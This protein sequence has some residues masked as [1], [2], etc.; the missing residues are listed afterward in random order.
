MR[1][2]LTLALAFGATTTA[3]SSVASAQHHHHGGGG[4]GHNRGYGNYGGY[5][6]YGRG[7]L[8]Y[9]GFGY[10]SYGFGGLGY[11]TYGYGGL[12]GGYSG[13]SLSTGFGGLNYYRGPV[14]A[15]PFYGAY[16]AYGGWPQAYVTQAP[17]IPPVFAYTAP[18]PANNP[19]L[20]EDAA[21]VAPGFNGA[22]VPGFDGAV[23]PNP[24][25]QL[26]Q[27]L[28]EQLQAEPVNLL[29][30]QPSSAEARL[31]SLRFQA[32]G[33]EWLAKRNWMQAYTHYKQAATTAI[34]LPA[35]R[36]RMAVALC[37]MNNGDLAVR[38][39][40]RAMRTDPLCVQTTD[41]LETIFGESGAIAR[42][43]M[44]LTVADWVR[45]DVR[46]PNRIL[47]MGTMLFLNEDLDQALP[48]LKTASTLL[49]SPEY[50]QGFFTKVEFAPAPDAKA[51]QVIEPGRPQINPPPADSED[52]PAPVAPTVTPSVQ[53]RRAP[54]RTPIGP[55]V[56]GVARGPE[57]VSPPSTTNQG[58]ELVPPTI[59]APQGPAVV[60]FPT[61]PAPQA[62]R[63]TRKIGPLLPDD[64][65]GDEF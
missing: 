8:G 5:R 19:V 1:W 2:F 22:A 35:P 55:K 62:V 16:G 58:P 33:D 14:Y 59:A 9:S 32:Q 3:F 25:A 37:A 34:D 17:V 45:E 50:M 29:N 15:G 48:F 4:F 23:N 57:I 26:E 10:R 61:R 28:R 13:F 49:G 7:G 53:N 42:N 43:G 11:S 63:P 36:L 54:V 27:Q 39:V 41:R 64:R 44:L 21:G 31:K 56:N 46:D 65:F 47:V 24:N 52:G 38:E 20:F 60:D 18:F 40:K 12:Y 30:L 51:P 6:G